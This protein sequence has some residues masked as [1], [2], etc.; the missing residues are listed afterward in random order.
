VA[1]IS[2]DAA[3]ADKL[4]AD[5]RKLAERVKT[6]AFKPLEIANGAKELLDEV[7]TKKITGE[8]DR[9]SHTDL[10]DFAANLAGA[11][12]AINSLR[13]AL[14]E[15]DA[16]LLADVDTHFAA[17]QKLL[18][19]YKVGDGYKLYTELTP[20]DTKALSDAISGLAE[21]ISKVAAAVSTEAPSPSA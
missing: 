19:T 7:A 1:D 2:K 8:E 21:P 18:D 14:A 12:A 4:D 9:Y 11:Q 13:P 3:L 15:R 16:D 10:W 6:V 5:V 20:T 17:A